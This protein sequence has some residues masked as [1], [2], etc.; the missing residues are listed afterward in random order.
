MTVCDL[1]IDCDA[2]CQR[3][4]ECVSARVG[5]NLDLYFGPNWTC[6]K[7][8]IMRPCDSI[9]SYFGKPVYFWNPLA[10]EGEAL[11]H[12]LHPGRFTTPFGAI[13]SGLSAQSDGTESRGGII[14]VG[15]VKSWMGLGSSTAASACTKS[16]WAPLANDMAELALEHP[17]VA[18][19]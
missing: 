9:A 1:P 10:A 2:M 17:K 16:F 18:P 8:C 11:F 7:S 6:E 13:C 19:G 12:V 15:S 3:S 5:P 14:R 4:T